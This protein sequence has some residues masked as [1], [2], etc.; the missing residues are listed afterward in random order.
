MAYPLT[1]VLPLKASADLSA[2][3]HLLGKGRDGLDQ[4]LTLLGTV[5]FAQ[6]LVLDASTT[7]L[8]PSPGSQGPYKLAVVLSYD[9]ELATFI[10]DFVDYAGTEFDKLLDFTAEGAVMTPVKGHLAAFAAFVADND[11]SQHL[12]NSQAAMFNAYQFPVE[13]IVAD[14]PT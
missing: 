2:L 5:H 10:K 11:A 12:P 9:G 6:F 4:A 3:G 7:S 8:Q 1:L 14:M 13:L